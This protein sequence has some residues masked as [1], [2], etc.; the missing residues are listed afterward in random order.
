MA[1]LK[2]KNS[3]Q[4]HP[5]VDLWDRPYPIMSTQ[6]PDSGIITH[7]IYI[8][9]EIGA[10]RE[11]SEIIALLDTTP[12]DALIVL[13]INSPGGYLDSALSLIEAIKF[14]EA[15]VVCELSGTVASAATM[16]ALACHNIDIAP[17][18]TFMIHNFSGGAMGKGHELLS[19]IEFMIKSNKAFFEDIYEGFLSEDEIATV[20]AGKDI[21][22][23]DDEVMERFEMV[24]MLRQ[25]AIDADAEEMNTRHVNSM[26]EVLEQQGYVVAKPSDTPLVK[27]KSK[28]KGIKP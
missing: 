28:P 5:M 17:Y 6:D 20:L 19:N 16:I 22:L 25:E 3:T 24:K 2:P 8:M 10:P 12:S 13:K 7:F 4:E 23:N 21:Y 18:T 26:K 14:S 15:T 27:P 9:D 11:F 1:K